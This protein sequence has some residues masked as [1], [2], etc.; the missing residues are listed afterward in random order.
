MCIAL[1]FEVWSVTA[2]GKFIPVLRENRLPVPKGSITQSF[3]VTSRVHA[4]VKKRN[5]SLPFKNMGETGFQTQ[6][7]LIEGHRLL[8]IR[9]VI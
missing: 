8:S 2:N 1:L 6:A 3:S 9:L 5:G 4:R 7:G